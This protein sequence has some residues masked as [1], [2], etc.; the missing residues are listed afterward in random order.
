[1]NEV[2]TLSERQVAT[3]KNTIAA[4][5]NPSEFNM[6]VD[7]ARRIGL[8]PIR[9]Q[10]IPL[11]FSKDNPAKR[12]LN[13]VVTVD[14]QRTIADRLRN[15][16]PDSDEP[17]I[18]YDEALKNPNTNPLGIEKCVVTLWK[19]DN[20]GEWF[21]VNGTVYWDEFAAVKQWGNQDPKLDGLWCTKPR[22][23]I[24]KCAE[25]QALRKGWPDQFANIYSDAEFDKELVDD[26]NASDVVEQYQE[27]QRVKMI[28]GDRVISFVFDMESGIER[29]AIGKVFDR[30][31]EEAK[32]C[33]DL[34]QFNQ[35]CSRNQEA[36]KEFWAYAKGDA[37]SLKS[38]LEKLEEA[39]KAKA[40]DE[41]S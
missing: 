38:E 12:K 7:Y 39:L 18:V 40:Y 4:D 32:K 26:R 16:R 25:S 36:L 23:M 34:L 19:Q 15:Y 3:L 21:K 20:K 22:I 31:Y 37:L 35:L 6:F 2:M 11:V 17:K 33:A 29:I 30:F 13:I 27:Q 14:G 1:M 41:A 28:G 24:T 9:G 10:V 8:D 5:C